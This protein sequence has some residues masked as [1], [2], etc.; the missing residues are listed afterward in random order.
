MLAEPAGVFW[1]VVL[2]VLVPGIVQ[3]IRWRRM[4]R[5]S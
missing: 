1:F 3:A 2:T 4:R 5:R